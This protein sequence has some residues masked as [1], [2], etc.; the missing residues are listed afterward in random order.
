MTSSDGRAS[1]V[2][3]PGALSSE[4]VITVDPAAAYPPAQLL[5]G[6]YDFGP[7]GTQFALPAMLTFAYEDAEIPVDDLRWA[8]VA[9]GQW[10]VLETTH[11]V[12]AR[13]LTAEAT[14][15]STYGAGMFPNNEPPTLLISEPA[16]DM[17]V[18]YGGMVQIEYTDDDPDDGAATW[19]FADK[20][21]DLDTID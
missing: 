3:P 9:N 1:I 6:A 12:S 18:S 2:I 8:G 21:G 15:F 7:E 14:H 5:L 19:L 13:M 11:D 4:T 16:S 10:V 20:D 17:L